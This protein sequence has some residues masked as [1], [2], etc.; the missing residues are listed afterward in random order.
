MSVFII[1][2]FDNFA[3]FLIWGPYKSVG[4]P[5]VWS[6]LVCFYFVTD[7]DA[8]PLNIPEAAVFPVKIKASTHVGMLDY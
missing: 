7:L 8:H 3:L 4:F 1:L 5:A 6:L 2:N